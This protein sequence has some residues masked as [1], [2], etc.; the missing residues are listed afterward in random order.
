MSIWNWLFGDV[1]DAMAMPAMN[2]PTINPATGLPMIGDDMGGI[3]V[4]GS[5]YGTDLHAST[6]WLSSSNSAADLG[7]GISGDWP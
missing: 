2:T 7:S 4:G 3:D 1:T 5:P 6:D